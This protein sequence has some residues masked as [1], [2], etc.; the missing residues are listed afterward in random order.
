MARVYLALGSN[1]G[2]RSQHLRDALTRL[3][4]KVTITEVS[5]LYVTEPWG[6][7]EQPSFLNMV[8]QGETNLEPRALLEFLKTIELDMGRTAGIRYGPRVIDVDILFYDDQVIETPEL[9]IPHP[10]L[11]ERR[12]V[13]VPLAEIASELI[14]PRLGEPV[15]LLLER[16][17][18]DEKVEV[19]RPEVQ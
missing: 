3:E 7:K 12:F 5:H 19:Y 16:L 2:N 14:H 10:R 6:M 13:L 4:D 11:T 8:V 17:S 9:T 18:A 15:H 1:I